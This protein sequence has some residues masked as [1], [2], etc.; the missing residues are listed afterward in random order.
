MVIVAATLDFASQE[1]RD[2]VVR[3]TT[4]VQLGTREEEAGCRAYCF[5]ADP[6]VPTRVQVHEL[7]DDA[8]SLA[9]HFSHPYYRRMVEI[10]TS[11]GLV[12]TWN[13]VYEVAR[14]APV[15]GPDGG[16]NPEFFR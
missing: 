9:A 16:A 11:A 8:A 10:L 2:E 13:Q 5:A 12:D 3:L 14:H 4:P 6:A 15:Y 7:W 1:T